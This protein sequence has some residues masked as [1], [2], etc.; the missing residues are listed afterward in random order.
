M[1]FDLMVGGRTWSRSAELAQQL[2]QAGFSGMLFTEAGQVPWMMIAAAATAKKVAAAAAAAA[3]V[4]PHPVPDAAASGGAD[5]GVGASGSGGGVNDG[6]GMY[7]AAVEA[8]GMPRY[9]MH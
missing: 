1:H 8:E 2:Q 6:A 3:P 9:V 7:G 4:F 5:A